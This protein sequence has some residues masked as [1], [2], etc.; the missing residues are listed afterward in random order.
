MAR[1]LGK[2]QTSLNPYESFRDINQDND[3][4]NADRWNK[5]A[6]EGRLA[7]EADI[8]R[9]GDSELGAY[10]DYVDKYHLDRATD[11]IFY[12]AV[13]KD[14]YAD[15]TEIKDWE[16]EVLNPDT[17]EYE[18][19][20][21]QMTEKQWIEH[22]LQNWIDYDN[23][24]IE[25]ELKEEEKANRPWIVKALAG[26]ADVGGSF[27]KGA[28]DTIEGAGRLLYSLI[29]A[30]GSAI[31]QGKNWGD[32]FR[33]DMSVP[34]EGS[35]NLER[36]EDEVLSLDD[37]SILRDANG[38]Y[39]TLGTYLSQ[40]TYTLGQM[41]P[42]MIANAVLP[43]IGTLG[44]YTST[45]PG[46]ASSVSKTIGRGTMAFYYTAMWSNRT[47]E[48]FQNPD[49]AST[50]TWL[51][52]LDST[53]K[54][55]TDILIEQGLRIFTGKIFGSSSTIDRL[56]YGAGVKGTATGIAKAASKL[57]TLGRVGYR[58]ARDFVSEGVEEVLQ[59]VFA[60][61][62]SQI[63]GLFYDS[64]NTDEI[65]PQSLLD[66]FVI[67]GLASVFMTG[68]NIAFSSKVDLD[69]EGHKLGKLQSWLYISDYQNL[70][71]FYDEL[72]TKDLTTEERAKVMDS[73][74][75]AFN[76]TAS[77]FRGLGEERVKQASELFTKVRDHYNMV[78]Q[79][80]K[81]LN[82][83]ST[84]ERLRTL[85]ETQRYKETS[86]RYADAVMKSLDKLGNDYA[87]SKLNKKTL[88]K[89]LKNKDGT[90]KRQTVA[91][92]L[93][94][95]D[96]TQVHDFIAKTDINDIQPQEGR[97]EK[98][99]RLAQKVANEL[100]KDVAYTDGHNT[101]NAGDVQLIPGEY[102]DT[103]EDAEVL[104]TIAENEFIDTLVSRLDKRI[105]DRIRNWWRVVQKDKRKGT[106]EDAVRALLFNDDFF[107]VS[108]AT[109]NQ[110]MY[111]F[112]THIRDVLNESHGTKVSDLMYQKII[113]DVLK[114][115]KPIIRE[116]VIN[117]QNANLNQLQDFFTEP[118]LK[119]II[120]NRWSFD[121]TNRILDNNTYNKLSEADNR[122][123]ENRINYLQADNTIKEQIR[124]DLKSSSVNVRVRALRMLDN[125]Y[126]NLFFSKYNDRIYF[127]PTS[128]AR[129]YFNQ[130]MQNLGI[131]LLEIRTGRFSKQFRDRMSKVLD[132]NGNPYTDPIQFLQD[133]FGQFTENGFAFEKRGNDIVVY[134][135]NITNNEV[136]IAGSMEYYNDLFGMMQMTMNDET[137]VLVEPSRDRATMKKFLTRITDGAKVNN[138]NLAF[139]SI[140]D[141]VQRPQDYLKTEELMN[142]REDYGEV[143]NYTTFQYLR[144][145]LLDEYETLTLVRYE[146]GQVLFADMT[147]AYSALLPSI[148]NMSKNTNTIFEKYV[149]KGPIA[150]EKFFDKA[151]LN[152]LLEGYTVE[153]VRDKSGN[154]GTH[155]PQTR[156]IVI[157]NSKNN[158]FTR[159]ALLHE[160]QHAIQNVN[161]L[162][163]GL[164]PY[165]I[166]SDALLQD[167]EK[168]LPQLFA[169]N[170]S[171]ESKKDSIR[172]FLYKTASGEIDAN[173][174]SDSVAFMGT[175]VRGTVGNQTHI[176][177][178][179]GTEHDIIVKEQGQALELPDY[180]TGEIIELIDKKK[181]K[182]FYDALNKLNELKQKYAKNGEIYSYPKS[183]E[184]IDAENYIINND[185]V[186][187]Y[188]N[189]AMG[190]EPISDDIRNNLIKL[191]ENDKE[192]K[193]QS[194][195]VANY[196][197]AP[198]VPFDEFLDMDI[199]YVRV[200]NN[201]YIYESNGLSVA[202]GESGLNIIF[203]Q[204]ANDT[205]VRMFVGTIKPKDLLA[206]IPDEF[207]EGL[208]SS[209]QFKDAKAFDIKAIFDN[210][211]VV[212]DIDD[213]TMTRADEW[214]NKK[215]YLNETLKSDMSEL[216]NS[217]EEN[218]KNDNFSTQIN[219]DDSTL[220]NP[221]HL[222][223][224]P[225]GNIYKG[226]Q[227][228]L[229]EIMA[230]YTSQNISDAIVD[231]YL[232]V[233]D[234]T[235]LYLRLPYHM[236]TQAYSKL[237]Q[238]I[239]TLIKKYPDKNIVL[240][241]IGNTDTNVTIDKN[242]G[243]SQQIYQQIKQ[244]NEYV[245][246]I[247]TLT[248]RPIDR[249]DEQPGQE[250]KRQPK[251]KQRVQTSKRGAHKRDNSERT[252][253][254]KAAS[255]GTNLA[256]FAGRRIPLDM[257]GFINEASATRLPGE[258][259]EKIENGTLNYYDV[260]R[261]FRTH[262]DLD[263]YTFQL[264]RKY[265][266]PN[267]W[268]KTNDQLRRFTD[269]DLAFYYA[270]QGVLYEAGFELDASKPMSF[271]N[272]M[273]LYEQISQNP[274]FKDRLDT[275]ATHFLEIKVFNKQTKKFE[276][277]ALDID[278]NHLRVAAMEMMDGSIDSAAHIIAL[279]RSI[280]LSYRYHEVWNTADIKKLKSL[281]DTTSGHKA[282]DAESG[283]LEDV[284]ADVKSS[285]DMMTQALEEKIAT[286]GYAQKI[287]LLFEY[288][289]D[290]LR[291][292][293][294]D[295]KNWS[296][297][298]QRKAVQ[299]IKNKIDS[300]TPEQFDNMYRKIVAKQMG[301]NFTETAIENNSVAKPVDKR[302]NIIASIKRFATTIKNYRSADQWKRVPD[303][304]KRYFDEDGNL[305]QE[306]YAHVELKP[307]ANGNYPKLQEMQ[308]K[309][310]AL[311][312]G[313]RRG[314]FT[315]KIAANAF[316]QA[317]KYKQ[318]YKKQKE[319]N[320]K[321]KNRY[322]LV[323]D[324]KNF[325]IQSNSREFKATA[326]IAMPDKLRK[327]FD[328]EFEDTRQ[329]TI[330]YI[331]KPDD[332]RQIFNQKHFYE[333]NADILTNLTS[334]DVEEII[335]FYD[336]A[337]LLEAEQESMDKF[338]AFKIYL[339]AYFIDE[340]R[341]GRWNI[342]SYYLERAEDILTTVTSSARELAVWRSVLYKINPN[343]VITQA[344]AKRLG[345]ELD[346][347]DVDNLTEATKTGDVKKILRAQRELV[348]NTLYRYKT[349]ADEP[350][351]NKKAV[352]KIT[353]KLVGETGVNVNDIISNP[354]KYFDNAQMKTIREEYGN[355]KS[356][357]FHYVQDF[358]IDN[359]H[360]VA[361]TQKDGKF[362]F[363]DFT[364]DKSTFMN[365]LLTFQKA[366][367][368]SS[369][370]TAIRNQISNAFIEQGSKAAEVFGKAFAKPIEK[371]DAWIRKL[372][373]RPH[374]ELAIEQID[375]I[376]VKV[377]DDVKNFIQTQ[378]IDAGVF[379]FIS[380]GA[381][382]Y[383]TRK[384]KTYTGM[385]ALTD[386]VVN[387]IINDITRG[388]TYNSDVMN[389]IIQQVFSWQSDSR[390]INRTAK[391]YLGKLLTAQNV[392]L[393]RGL[394]EEV[395]TYIAEAYK[396][397]AFDYMHKTN[398]ISE[399]E[400][401]L[402]E[403]APKV[404]AGYK[405]IF[406]FIP[407]SWNWFVESINW[408][409]VGLVKNIVQL[410]R[411]EKTV[412]K[413]LLDR[414]RG[415]QTYDPRLAKYVITRN[416]GKGVMG[417]L[418]MGLGM[419]LGGLGVFQVDDDDD[420]L[421]IKIG[422]V[423]F[424]INNIFG[425]SSI[426]LGA[427]LMNPR[428]GSISE[429][430]EAAFGA[431][432]ED[433]WL[434]DIANMFSYGADSVWDVL[435]DKPTDILG[436]FVPNFLKSL[437]KLFYT[438]EVKYDSGFLGNLEYLAASSIPFLAYAFPKKI[439]PF[440][441]E[442]QS[443]YGLP[444]IWDF[445]VDLINV[446][447][448]MQVKPHVV[449]EQ[450]RIAIE[451]GLNKQP[452]TGKYE[453]IGQVDYTTLNMKYGSLNQADLIKLLNNQVKYTVEEEDGK[454]RDK[455][456]RQMTE[457]QKKT[458]V[459]RIMSNNSRYA[460]IYTWTQAG[461]K[462]Y[463][464]NSEYTTLKK[465][466]ITKNIFK[467]DKGFVA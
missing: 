135:T 10:A 305:K 417:S 134:Q 298:K 229:N 153:F 397:A 16:E 399:L 48:R 460:K 353:K 158:A 218:I 414:Q 292:K 87:K 262:H 168:N 240:V 217:I 133:Q 465:L 42:T 131:N 423:Y 235:N 67:A 255:K 408:S 91:E 141:I 226:T 317:Q 299:V 368:L 33:E 5:A 356:D 250:Q 47:T 203:E 271:N 453:D 73:M 197:L 266:F 251:A 445:L 40:I 18:T 369:P 160:F 340:A 461:H 188:L 387:N 144:N 15:N 88:F 155:N 448:P 347:G 370:A 124:K 200:Q 101:V 288:Y 139:T 142:I 259:W 100:N 173:L 275:K 452:L 256:P 205:I 53:I 4:Y 313:L 451:L 31:F 74:R 319:T 382:K 69:G 283:T 373:K 357:V 79:K 310:G 386:M 273:K 41:A 215:V 345:V 241:N 294:P 109:A 405:M 331:A 127:E 50:P 459:E 242:R 383:D 59:D 276:Y 147:D 441:G 169:E 307:D 89:R 390:F 185:I 21:Y 258:L 335:R 228:N 45:V 463:A 297:Q 279:A 456:W 321:L 105:L 128:P 149:G 95:A 193:K 192:F 43:G 220:K 77:V 467:G 325:I 145:L 316:Q 295:Y 416:V 312:Q 13:S 269:L 223:I 415:R 222:Y 161:R 419:L 245:N 70:A 359:T 172:W 351:K 267:S 443:K 209:K 44:A 290:K 189:N 400:N 140:N 92:K 434:N 429:V 148:A 238:T 239:Q 358:V 19:K 246:N 54:T 308:T 371:T 32:V 167:F 264:I 154:A 318:L 253:V 285:Q 422:D 426:I 28:F 287:E 34:Y 38:N 237:L 164:S 82:V 247:N 96:V 196:Y 257:Q 243:I 62:S 30:S 102:A 51:I 326:N 208:I 198:E 401:K 350:T 9:R 280:A 363:V 177:T 94:D 35:E 206:Y 391:R 162:A 6:R 330:K 284:I 129:N 195:I 116:F 49:F 199:P 146:N 367:M 438:H 254:S 336:S 462:Y 406:P 227:R 344:L 334:D 180:N 374:G 211:Q 111:Q 212:T 60:N 442:V 409:P 123:I 455:Y 260:H 375:I 425:T 337:V 360:E 181:Y 301:V 300:L 221:Q 418:L 210:Y 194:L 165:F 440:T 108:F 64:F 7:M 378:V 61:I 427:E 466:G 46:V 244:N 216:Y 349:I 174:F 104:R 348:R 439:D 75:A 293:N 428:Q 78:Q 143:N 107:A 152:P 159:F 431:I 403:R 37:W 289:G 25:Q 234:D 219:F 110:E 186:E 355:N 377:T 407:T 204:Y 93:T 457:E 225:S 413:L 24:M 268:F 265:F 126:N 80:E 36:F 248:S 286:S 261:Y 12:A 224:L 421:K 458:V 395:M 121:L 156:T 86:I 270:L 68:A 187:Q 314:D 381:S 303:D 343:K 362:I 447:S 202:L 184:V 57:G 430:L 352:D 388:N 436:T 117:Q 179:W 214:S 3:W 327:M 122:V 393:S 112:I 324:N 178:P 263:E 119:D 130:L 274:S 58:I 22:Q 402:R 201:K 342:D 329:S 396:L 412:D 97:S 1:V 125:E 464:S 432:T 71:S 339:L 376:G 166:V 99:T 137:G 236:T 171:V 278:Q 392:D 115:Y 150:I 66:T 277:Q 366:A 85:S 411:L 379:E 151:R 182:K 332:K 132:A 365:K 136:Y 213:S 249:L 17:N 2:P 446:A 404:Y 410:C 328:T 175:L 291:R 311:A 232:G 302:K 372:I 230:M 23:Y 191:F 81:A 282:D 454:R 309:L 65:T 385:D 14:L 322:A 56:M 83:L 39:T 120:K 281:Q 52:M 27:I 90:T 20:K 233:F 176:I 449:S 190:D 118:E 103:H 394:S 420:K 437:N 272:F 433:A 183:Q 170:A 384:S 444:F 55:T 323:S 364:S 252:Y 207:N 354:E 435:L 63:E 304:Y 296:E 84:D 11:D 338:R 346:E 26:V 114:R 450:E 389:A 98:R 76:V 29:D 231:L 138:V 163:G 106:Y 333:V 8:I 380:E 113:E 424:N 72:L 315:T 361:L 306:Y 320:Q 398:V 157:N 341:S